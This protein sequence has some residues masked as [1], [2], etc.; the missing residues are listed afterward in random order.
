[1]W[2]V[3]PQ[4][5]LFVH[6]MEFSVFYLQP[7][8]TALLRRNIC[9]PAFLMWSSINKQ[10]P[11]FRGRRGETIFF[12]FTAPARQV[13][14][15]GLSEL[16]L[17]R[18]HMSKCCSHLRPTLP[19]V[20]PSLRPGPPWSC[21]SALAA[22]SGHR[23]RAESAQAPPWDQ[24]P[25]HQEET[26]DH[27]RP[28]L[29]PHSPKITVFIFTCLCALLR[30]SSLVTSLRWERFCGEMF[31]PSSFSFPLSPLLSHLGLVGLHPPTLQL[32]APLASSL[33][34]PQALRSAG[35]AGTSGKSEAENNDFHQLPGDG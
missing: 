7:P 18:S 24:R 4:W 28:F 34:C 2:C 27:Q 26:G 33:S 14:E 3:H 10:E 20:R 13:H 15:W 29:P 8:A 32:G 21:G 5:Q 17:Q 11:T 1:M 16:A 31:L 6:R 30:P 22:P 19:E 25:T 23:A 12:L 9:N 35:F